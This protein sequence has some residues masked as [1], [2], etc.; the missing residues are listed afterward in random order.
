[1]DLIAL[2]LSRVE[3][4]SDTHQ[5]VLLLRNVARVYERDLDDK[6]QAFDALLIAWTQDFTD[7][8][9]AR[10]VER[11]AGLTQRWNEL[12]TTANQSLS[13]LDPEDTRVRNAICLKCARWY[14]REGHPEYAIPYLQQVL[15]VD[16]VNRPA[17]RQMAELYRQTQQ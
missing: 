16:P 14:G 7:E 17:M 12:L 5:R 2:Y 15:S 1:E 3:A 6:A 9:S 11:M 8:E 4:A 13:D 10:D